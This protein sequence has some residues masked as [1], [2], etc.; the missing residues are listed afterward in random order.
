MLP[1]RYALV[2][3]SSFK[4]KDADRYKTFCPADNVRQFRKLYSFSW[5]CSARQEFAMRHALSIQHLKQPLQVN[6]TRAL[7]SIA[8]CCYI[9]RHWCW[10]SGKNLSSSSLLLLQALCNQKTCKAVTTTVVPI[11]QMYTLLSTAVAACV[12]QMAQGAAAVPVHTIVSWGPPY[13]AQLH[14]EPVWHKYP[15]T[16]KAEQGALCKIIRSK[17]ERPQMLWRSQSDT[18]PCKSSRCTK[19][20]SYDTCKRVI[21]YLTKHTCIPAKDYVVKGSLL[22]IFESH[23]LSN[24]Q[25]ILLKQTWQ[26]LAMLLVWLLWLQVL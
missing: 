3:G 18:W 11:C 15:D 23:N 10:C 2:S 25:N 16:D 7:H 4:C 1:R 8:V 17:I 13:S 12:F 19:Q 6:F 20:G 5:R 24:F 21:P 9:W 14:V 22:H 26:R